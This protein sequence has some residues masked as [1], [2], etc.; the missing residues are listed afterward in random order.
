MCG[1]GAVELRRTRLAC[2]TSLSAADVR[3][4]LSAARRLSCNLTFRHH[5]KVATTYSEASSLPNPA[6]SLNLSIRQT[7][8]NPLMI[9]SGTIERQLAVLEMCHCGWATNIDEPL[10]NIR[11]RTARLRPCR[12]EAL[13]ARRACLAC[14][15]NTFSPQTPTGNRSPRF[16]SAAI[17]TAVRNATPG[18][19]SCNV[20]HLKTCDTVEPVRPFMEMWLEVSPSSV[21]RPVPASRRLLSTL[22]SALDTRQ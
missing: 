4:F 22:T 11:V 12:S 6:P 21:T 16:A 10:N 19:S 7:R 13:T 18:G 1:S 2:G 15:S 8:I 9:P 20:L 3:V 5:C 17:Q 14:N